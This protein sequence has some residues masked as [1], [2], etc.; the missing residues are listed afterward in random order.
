MTELEP[1]PAIPPDEFDADLYDFNHERVLVFFP[2]EYLVVGGGEN[3]WDLYGVGAWPGEHSGGP[4]CT[5][6]ERDA[7]PA[8]LAEWVAGRLGYPVRLFAGTQTISPLRNGA[9]TEWHEEPLYV[10]RPAE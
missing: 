9:P 8:R 2:G 7:D 5:D 1:F 6:G 3:A 4:N 10:V